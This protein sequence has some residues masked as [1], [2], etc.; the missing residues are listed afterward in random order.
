MS[1][2]MFYDLNQKVSLMKLEKP[3]FVGM[4]RDFD[5][6]IPII[7]ETSGKIY[8]SWYDSNKWAIWK[9]EKQH[10]STPCSPLLLSVFSTFWKIY[11]LFLSEYFFRFCFFSKWISFSTSIADC[12]LE[13]CCFPSCS[14]QCPSWIS[15]VS[16]ISTCFFFTFLW[17]LRNTENKL[18]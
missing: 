18:N 4:K 5:E 6:R 13:E 8:C 16:F 9:R 15:L 12:Y 11:G 3:R 1:K 2:R 10:L 14:S 7:R 17:Q